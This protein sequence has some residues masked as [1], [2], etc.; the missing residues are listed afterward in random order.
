MLNNENIQSFDR[1]YLDRGAQLLDTVFCGLPGLRPL[2][3]VK[4]PRE[5][6]Q[7]EVVFNVSYEN[8][9]ELSQVIATLCQ[10]IK[11]QDSQNELEDLMLF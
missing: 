2:V 11:E 4:S 3:T 8:P 10:W 1:K 9:A 7:R 5:C 6:K